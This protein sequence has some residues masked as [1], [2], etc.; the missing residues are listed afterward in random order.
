[1]GMRTPLQ[2]LP[3][4][5]FGGGWNPPIPALHD[6][7]VGLLFVGAHAALNYKKSSRVLLSEEK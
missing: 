3:V 2:A 7:P 6:K 4:S 1:M 5:C